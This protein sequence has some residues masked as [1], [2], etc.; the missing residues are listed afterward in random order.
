MAKTNTKNCKC[1]GCEKKEV[2]Y[3]VEVNQIV[4]S[5]KGYY[6]LDCCFEMGFELKRTIK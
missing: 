1:L 6:C 4:G 3:Y 2:C 5:F